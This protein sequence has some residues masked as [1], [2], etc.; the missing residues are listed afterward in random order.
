MDQKEMIEQLTN[1]ILN[2]EGHRIFQDAVS[3]YDLGESEYIDLTRSLYDRFEREWAERGSDDPLG[4]NPF[5]II[6]YLEARVALLAQAGD[7]GYADW[8]R[9]MFELAVRFSDQAGLG[10][11]FR[12]FQELVASTKSDLQREERSVFFYTRALNRLA[13]L[14]EYWNGKDDARPLWHE[15]MT[16]IDQHMEPEDRREGLHVIKENAPWFAGEHPEVFA[17]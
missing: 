8:M 9:D 16:Y 12:L 7:E 17:A 14:T 4:V 1:L 5:E 3:S 11:K 2:H 13:Q 10:R 6:A 15:L